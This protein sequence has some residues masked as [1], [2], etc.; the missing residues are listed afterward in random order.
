MNDHRYIL[1]LKNNFGWGSPNLTIHQKKFQNSI[2]PSKNNI[3][4][5]VTD[6]R[7]N[8]LFA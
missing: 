2:T 5:T 8:F 4:M 3:G 7:V 6:N 1:I